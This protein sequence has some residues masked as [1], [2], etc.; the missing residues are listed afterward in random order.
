VRVSE[1]HSVLFYR[2]SAA[3]GKRFQNAKKGKASQRRPFR[4]CNI[5][6]ANNNYLAAMVTRR[7]RSAVRAVSSLISLFAATK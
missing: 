7:E 6:F 4:G 3:P 1:A 2:N 5:V